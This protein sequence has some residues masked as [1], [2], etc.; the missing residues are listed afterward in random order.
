[1]RTITKTAHARLQVQVEEASVQSKTAATED[2]REKMFKIAETIK[3]KLDGTSVREDSKS[4]IYT[5]SQLEQDVEDVLWN[6]AIRVSDY[7]NS[8]LDGV[9]TNEVVERYANK[10]INEMRVKLGNAHGVGAYEPGVPGEDKNTYVSIEI[11]EEE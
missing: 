6:A 9:E 7:F 3:D 2:E 5:S 1:M 4:Y 8:T 10:F 11:F